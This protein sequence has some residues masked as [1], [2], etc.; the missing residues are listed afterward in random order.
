VSWLTDVS[1]AYQLFVRPYSITNGWLTAPILV[2]AQ[3]GD[4]SVWPGDT[5][6]INT[7]TDTKVILS[8]GSGVLVNNQPKAQI[9]AA[10]VDFTL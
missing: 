6:G 5:T 7:L 1:G 9:F 3:S 8:W 4:V 10:I 2:S